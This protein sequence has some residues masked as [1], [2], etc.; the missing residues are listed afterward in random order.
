VTSQ[1]RIE[2]PLESVWELVSD[3]GN[4]RRWSP[5]SIGMRR[6]SGSGAYAVGDK[7]AGTNRIWLP[8]TTFCTVTQVSPLRRFAF[9]ASFAGAPIAEWGYTLAEVDGGCVV[10]ET[11]DDRRHAAARLALVPLSMALGR[12]RDAAAHNSRAMAATLAALKAEA[13]A[14][15]GSAST[16]T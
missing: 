12:G 16:E 13:E 10:T 6:L 3:P 1:I 14:A 2:A 8:W 5:E 9:L 15:A 7:F 4:Y 11:W